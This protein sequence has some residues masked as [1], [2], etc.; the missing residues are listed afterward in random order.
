MS[1]KTNSASPA[2]AEVVGPSHVALEVSDL[3]RSIQFWRS[4]FGYTIFADDSADPRQPSVKGVVGGFGVELVQTLEPVGEFA[5]RS[6]GSPLG[7]VV[8]SFSVANLDAA[9]E[10][11]K[12]RKLVDVEA[13]ADIRGVRFF[14]VYDPDGRA[15]E[16]IQF[17][18]PITA[19]A[20]L[21]A[22]I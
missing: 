5:S 9:F 22:Y 13:P 8:L 21:S 16:L 19:L 7:S 10:K 12:A 1:M 4:V 11:L 2:I 20:D 17:P 14:S 6:P 18:H 3:G 15:I